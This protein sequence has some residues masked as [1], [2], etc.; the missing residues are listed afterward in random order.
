[1]KTPCQSDPEM[2]VSDQLAARVEAAGLCIN[3]CP[4]DTQRAC[5]AYALSIKPK[6]G[7]YAGRDWTTRGPSER[8]TKN[9]EECRRKFERHPSEGRAAWTA[10]R[11]C[12]RKCA[13]LHRKKD[14]A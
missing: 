9:C 10:R 12:S 1:M 2:W 4:L 13:A 7:V 14:A 5:A 6:F 11:F 3:E 8:G